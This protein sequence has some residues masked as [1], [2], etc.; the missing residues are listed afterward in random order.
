[1]QTSYTRLE[2][3]KYLDS[4]MHHDADLDV[5]ASMQ[6]LKTLFCKLHH[7]CSNSSG[8]KHYWSNRNH[9]RNRIMNC[10]EIPPPLSPA[11]ICAGKAFHNTSVEGSHANLIFLLL[12]IT[13]PHSHKA[14]HCKHA[15]MFKTIIQPLWPEVCVINMYPL[16]LYPHCIIT[17]LN[18]LPSRET[19]F[20]YLSGSL[21]VA[22]TVSS[23][24]QSPC[25]RPCC[26][27]FANKSPLCDLCLH[28]QTRGEQ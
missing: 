12:N 6:T 22:P 25:L 21:S 8:L 10:L 14:H 15:V 19:I 16:S 20:I 3:R 18:S 9:Y 28:I 24:W 26:F 4:W 11:L 17:R 7:T 5:S 2:V 23:P 13:Q 1:M 27:L